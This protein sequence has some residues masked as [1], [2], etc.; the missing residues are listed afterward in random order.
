MY[1]PA[2]KL[3]EEIHYFMVLM[4]LLFFCGRFIPVGTGVMSLD[5]ITVKVSREFQ[6]RKS[7]S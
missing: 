5:K 4:G 6:I 1:L 3:L 7:T 2:F